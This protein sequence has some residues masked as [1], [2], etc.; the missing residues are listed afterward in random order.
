MDKRTTVSPE[1]PSSNLPITASA[2]T[3][4]PAGRTNTLQTHSANQASFIYPPTFLDRAILKNEI[5][6]IGI[7]AAHE[8]CIAN[9]PIT[10]IRPVYSRKQRANFEPNVQIEG[11]PAFGLSL[12]NAGLGMSHMT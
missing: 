2:A 4:M 5:H 9:V 6:I 12:S 3:A 1:L 8:I 11:Q 7:A 10:I